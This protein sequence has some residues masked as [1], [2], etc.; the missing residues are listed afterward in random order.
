MNTGPSQWPIFSIF[1]KKCLGNYYNH[2]SRE[3]G[4]ISPISDQIWNIC[5]GARDATMEEK[6]LQ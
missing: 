6:K 3:R 2:S 1:T 5:Q 4:Q